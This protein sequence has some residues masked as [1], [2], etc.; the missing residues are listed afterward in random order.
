MAWNSP[1]VFSL[2]PA[3]FRK[4][5]KLIGTF[6]NNNREVRFLKAPLGMDHECYVDICR[7]ERRP[8]GTKRS[9]AAHENRALPKNIPFEAGSSGLLGRG[10]LK[11]SD[12][13]GRQGFWARTGYWAYVRLRDKSGKSNQIGKHKRVCPYQSVTD[14]NLQMARDRAQPARWIPQAAINGSFRV[15]DVCM[16]RSSNRVTRAYRKLTDIPAIKTP[17]IASRGPKTRQLDGRI[18]SPYPTVE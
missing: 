5:S 8:R 15:R 10:I 14:L 4:M 17:V 9:Q 16:S 1:G 2:C 7:E 12:N 13:P 18:T 3:T 6:S 11:D